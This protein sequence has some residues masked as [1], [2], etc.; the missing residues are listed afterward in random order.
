[1]NRSFMTC[2][3]VTYHPSNFIINEKTLSMSL[4]GTSISLKLHK[5]YLTQHALRMMVIVIICA[6][7]LLITCF[8]YVNKRHL[9]V[10]LSVHNHQERNRGP[11]KLTC[12]QFMQCSDIQQSVS[13]FCTRAIYSPMFANGSLHPICG[14]QVS[15]MWPAE[16][17]RNQVFLHVIC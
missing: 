15:L 6:N 5:G 9:F 8:F 16:S 10:C 3:V 14:Q 7:L 12:P 11:T 2:F 1:M 4:Q 17:L 13:K